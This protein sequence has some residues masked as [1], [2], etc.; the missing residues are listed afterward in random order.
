MSER[1]YRGLLIAIT[2]GA[3]IALIFVNALGLLWTLPS[4]MR[5]P[6]QGPLSC[7]IGGLMTLTL[8]FRLFLVERDEAVAAG[9]PGSYN[10]ASFVLLAGVFSIV[11]AAILVYLYIR[12]F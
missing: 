7:L 6:Y 10:A 12:N 11:V 9:R 5:L 1:A 8:S 2:V 3:A 4:G